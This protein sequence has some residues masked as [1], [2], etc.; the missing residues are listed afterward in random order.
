M[1]AVVCSIG[2]YGKN[3]SLDCRG[4]RRGWSPT[5]RSPK[6]E[7]LRRRPAEPQYVGSTPTP[8]SMFQNWTRLT[9]DIHET[10]E[11]F[12]L[13]S[14]CHFEQAEQCFLRDRVSQREATGQSFF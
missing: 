1:D 13:P 10:H 7:R 4:K 5:L 3:R 9:A 8:G 14:S 6:A 2:L 12:K 11:I